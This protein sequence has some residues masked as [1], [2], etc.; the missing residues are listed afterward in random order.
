M[1]HAAELAGLGRIGRNT[2]LVN[3]RFGNMI[4]LSAVLLGVELEGDPIDEKEICPTGCRAC[5]RIC[6]V[7]ALDS[8]LSMNQKACW[9]HAFGSPS[10]GGEWRIKCFACRSVC[11]HALGHC[12]SD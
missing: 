3:R 4:W 1:K 6:P 2:L 10:Q 11:S 5:I 8:G 7:G 9:E 12:V